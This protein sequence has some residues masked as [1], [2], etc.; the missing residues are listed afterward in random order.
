MVDDVIAAQI[1]K[2][3]GGRNPVLGGEIVT[4]D[5]YA[6]ILCSLHHCLDRL[7]MSAL[8]D[9]HVGCARLRSHLRLEPT[10]IH[11]LHVSHDGNFRKLG[12]QRTDTIHS[13]GSDEGSAR[14]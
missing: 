2:P 3:S 7:W 13:F 12:A 5:L 9:D 4:H 11:D 8:H 10:A 14:L 1:L 6:E